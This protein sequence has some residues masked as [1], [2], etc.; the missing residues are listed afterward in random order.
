MPTKSVGTIVQR[1][2]PAVVVMAIIFLASS[3]P[4]KEMP[5]FG[6][7]DFFV[8]KGGHMLGYALMALAM[9]RGMGQDKR[10]LFWVVLGLVIAYAISDEFHQRFVAG[11]SSTYVDVL[12]DTSG[13]LIGYGG[14]TVFP[15]LKKATRLWMPS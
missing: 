14:W 13:A 7:I 12:I 9:I 8:K 10:H 6:A 3:T 11:R 4:S 2:G 5:S 1:W 15:W